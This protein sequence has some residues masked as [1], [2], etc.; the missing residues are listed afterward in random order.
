MAFIPVAN[1][2]KIEA[3]YWNGNSYS[4]NVFHFKASAALDEAA[5]VD[6]AEDLHSWW[7]TS[8]RGFMPPTLFLSKI[9]VSDLTSESAP[10]IEYTA[11]LPSPGTS[12]GTILPMNV[13]AA[14]KW[15]TG[16]R[17]RS[18]RGRTFMVGLIEENVTGDQIIS[19]ALANY[20]GVFEYL[21]NNTFSQVDGGLAVVSR[22]HNNAPRSQGVATL[23]TDVDIDPTIDSQRRR[24]L[25]R[26]Q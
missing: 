8:A 7:T 3:V 9:I 21:L 5:L 26:G 13:T 22:Y 23:I 14:V 1:T 19:A 17:G 10:A 4:E 25:G 12:S 16:Y 6:L 24:L 2:A 20:K 11:G 18:Y 15:T